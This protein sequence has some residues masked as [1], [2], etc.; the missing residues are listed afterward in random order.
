MGAVIDIRVIDYMRAVC[1]ARD[2]VR[3]IASAVERNFQRALS[4]N[5]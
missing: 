4:L 2:A 3:G 5:Q 1:D